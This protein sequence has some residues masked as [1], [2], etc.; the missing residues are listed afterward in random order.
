MKNWCLFR[1]ILSDAQCTA[2]RTC[3][4]I[5]QNA[6]IQRLHFYVCINIIT[7][8]NCLVLTFSPHTQNLFFCLWSVSLC[9]LAKLKAVEWQNSFRNVRGANNNGDDTK[10]ISIFICFRTNF[11][12][13]FFTLFLFVS[14]KKKKIN[15]PM[16]LRPAKGGQVV[17]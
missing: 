1:T 17:L 15:W 12:Q 16:S 4:F 2:G 9:L 6:E 11:F 14:L 10:F 7:L 13:S 8:Y 5:S 3:S